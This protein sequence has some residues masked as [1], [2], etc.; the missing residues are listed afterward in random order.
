MKRQYKRF[1]RMMAKGE[2]GEQRG[3]E[4]GRSEGE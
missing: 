1:C 4:K 2:L 3:I